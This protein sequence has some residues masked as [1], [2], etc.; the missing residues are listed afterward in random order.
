MVFVKVDLVGSGGSFY[1][2][3]SVVVRVMRFISCIIAACT[4]VSSVVVFANLASNFS[5]FSN[6]GF[7]SCMKK[8][9][10]QVDRA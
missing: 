5:M 8:V 9:L 2:N 7:L 3:P 6:I 10:M 1:D 4:G